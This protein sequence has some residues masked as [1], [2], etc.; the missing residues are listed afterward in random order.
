LNRRVFDAFSFFNELDILEIR[1]NTLDPYVDYFIINESPVNFN[2]GKKPLYYEENKERYKKFWLKIIHRVITDYPTTTGILPNDVTKGYAY[3][4]CVDMCNKADW[5]PKDYLPYFSDTWGKESLF[6]SM[7]GFCKPNDIIMLSDADEIPNPD[8]L[9]FIFDN[10]DENQVYNLN[11]NWYHYYLNIRKKQDW[12]GNIILTFNN[13]LSVGMCELKMKRRGLSI[14]N[15]GWHFSH[16]NSFDKIIE[17]L[18]SSQEHTWDVELFKNNLRDSIDNALTC[19]H[20]LHFWPSEFEIV[21]INTMPQ[22]V[23]DNQD[24]FKDLLKHE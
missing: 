11:Q 7:D 23:I 6:Y 22:Y 17:R 12:L 19:G 18:N 5:F 4:R 13:F 20:D 24:K 21:N 16:V 2:G 8:A 15:G 9:K 14:S 10:F 3:N 1:L